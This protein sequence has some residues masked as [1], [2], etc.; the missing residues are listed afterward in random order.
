M[1]VGWGAIQVQD[2]AVK[3]KCEHR[4]GRGGP[5]TLLTRTS[6]EKAHGWSAFESMNTACPFLIG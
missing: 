2:P 3:D 1:G 4:E 5:S 6:T